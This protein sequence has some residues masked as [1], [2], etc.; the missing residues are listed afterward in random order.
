MYVT[1]QCVMYACVCTHS[2]C[3]D[4]PMVEM[5]ITEKVKTLIKRFNTCLQMV[6]RVDPLL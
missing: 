3:G 6:K 5:K 4:I 1:W 2:E